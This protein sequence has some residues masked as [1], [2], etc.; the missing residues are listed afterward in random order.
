MSVH[1]YAKGFGKGESAKKAL[2]A[3]WDLGYNWS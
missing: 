2:F 3:A 1:T